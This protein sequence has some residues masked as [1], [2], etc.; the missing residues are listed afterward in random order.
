MFEIQKMTQGP[1]LFA[2]EHHE[3]LPENVNIERLA[4][5]AKSIVQ[6]SSGM[7]RMLDSPGADSTVMQ[8][9]C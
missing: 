8:Q 3:V 5:K 7:G 9:T 1:T 2:P 4:T 6:Q